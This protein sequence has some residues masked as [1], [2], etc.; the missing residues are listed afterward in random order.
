MF[1]LDCNIQSNFS[2]TTAQHTAHSLTFCSSAQHFVLH[3]HICHC[4]ATGDEFCKAIEDKEIQPTQEQ[5][6]RAR[7]LADNYDWDITFYLLYGLFYLLYG[8]FYLLYG[9]FYLLYGLGA[10]THPRR[11][12]RLG[13]HGRPQDLGLRLSPRWNLQRAGGHHQGCT[14]PQRNQGMCVWLLTRMYVCM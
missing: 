8:L 1:C 2:I 12:L 9:L 5:K 3:I 14:V 13:Y 10:C 6:V 7:I 4:T 11:R